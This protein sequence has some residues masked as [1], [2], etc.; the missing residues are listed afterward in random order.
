MLDDIFFVVQVVVQ[1]VLYQPSQEGDIGAGTNGG[2]DVRFRGRAGETR[3]NV[4]PF[5]MASDTHLKETG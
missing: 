3:I 5:C 1:D 2:I 4:A